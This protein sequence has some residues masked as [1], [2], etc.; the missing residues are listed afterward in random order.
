MSY[1]SF[2][3]LGEGVFYQDHSE[4]D[5]LTL[6][7]AELRLAQKQFGAGLM[8]NMA[9]SV[10]D[11]ARRRRH[12]TGV[13]GDLLPSGSLRL[14]L[15]R[16]VFG[17]LRAAFRETAYQLTKKRDDGWLSR[18]RCLGAANRPGASERPEK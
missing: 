16:S 5:D 15:G 12:Y 6:R 2:V 18:R 8:G 10:A 13:R 11:F 14:P 17:S 1:Y 3:L 4:N 9:A 7:R